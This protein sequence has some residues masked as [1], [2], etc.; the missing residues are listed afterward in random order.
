MLRSILGYLIQKKQ[1][2]DGGSSAEGH[3]DG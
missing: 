2:K 3:Q 1:E